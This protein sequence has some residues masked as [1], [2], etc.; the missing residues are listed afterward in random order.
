MQ[1]NLSTEVVETIMNSLRASK[2]DLKRQMKKASGNKEQII[3][4][5]LSDVE[6]AIECIEDGGWY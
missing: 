2:E 3:K 1:M 5:Q 6:Y 4:H